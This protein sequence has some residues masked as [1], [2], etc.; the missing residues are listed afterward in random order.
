M[1]IYI[2]NGLDYDNN[3]TFNV[4]FFTTSE[5]CDRNHIFM[6]VFMQCSNQMCNNVM[7]SWYTLTELP[8]YKYKPGTWQVKYVHN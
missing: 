8:D 5:S 1:C 3:R 6:R 4:A 7:I 2:I